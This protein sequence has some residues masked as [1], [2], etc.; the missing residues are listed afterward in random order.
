MI[1]VKGVKTEFIYDNSVESKLWQRTPEDAAGGRGAPG[2]SL[3][4]TFPV[5]LQLD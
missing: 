3:S 4:V 5:R 2:A 1:C